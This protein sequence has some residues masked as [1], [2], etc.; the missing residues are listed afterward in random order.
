MKDYDSM[1]GNIYLENEYVY[2]HRDTTES[3][4]ARNYPVIVYTIGNDA[5]LGIWDDNKGKMTF[6]N[7]YDSKF[8]PDNYKDMNPTNEVLTKN[9]TIY[10]FGVNGNGRFELVHTTPSVTN[11]LINYPKILLPNGDIITKYTIT[12]TFRRACDLTNNIPT[13]PISRFI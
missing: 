12:L 6:A 9:G 2:P 7:T 8:A 3:I 1:I 13:K 5:G 4:T 10:T 11:K